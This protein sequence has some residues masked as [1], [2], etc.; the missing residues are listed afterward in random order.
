VPVEE[1]TSLALLRPKQSPTLGSV[2]SPDQAVRYGGMASDALSGAYATW[3]AGAP[4]AAPSM[5]EAGGRMAVNLASMLGI[6]PEVTGAYRA[7]GGDVMNP[8]FRTAQLKGMMG[9][10]PLG[11]MTV[12]H[13]SPHVFDKFKLDKIGTGEG[14]QTYGHG[15][16]FAEKPG[17]AGSYRTAG[18]DMSGLTNDMGKVAEEFY[19]ALG[20]LSDGTVQAGKY[21]RRIGKDKFFSE[22]AEQ[23]LSPHDFPAS[24]REKVEKVL[25]PKGSLY[26][27]DIPDD[28]IAKMLDWDK[29]L[30]EQPESVRKALASLGV[31]IPSAVVLAEAKAQRITAFDRWHKAESAL[32]YDGVGSTKNVEHLYK[33]FLAE[34][35]AEQRL[36]SIEAWTG[37]NAYRS[38]SPNSDREASEILVAAGIPGLKY[39]DGT[40]RSAGEGTRNLVLFDENLAKILKRE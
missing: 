19:K 18:V 28:D 13:G 37:E 24:V 7:A 40:S 31:E 17:V 10:I 2:L 38:L 3:K 1:N 21:G 14:N 30:S 35:S 34:Q 5:K 36:N 23:K 22:F 33:G 20:P 25:M 8:A 15:M 29:P 16:Y 6:T 27:V 9:A 12:Y 32:R 4:V 26:H 11:G 39:F